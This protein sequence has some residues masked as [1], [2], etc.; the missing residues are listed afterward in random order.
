MRACTNHP[1][2]RA[3]YLRRRILIYV[4]DGAIEKL[5]SARQTGHP[6]DQQGAPF[7]DSF[8]GDRELPHV[9]GLSMYARL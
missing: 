9:F 1:K 3:S 7:S 6:C 4:L 8:R 5:V 2:R